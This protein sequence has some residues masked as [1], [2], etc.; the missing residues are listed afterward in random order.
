MI[1]LNFILVLKNLVPYILKVNLNIVFYYF[2]N[3]CDIENKFFSCYLPNRDKKMDTINVLYRKAHYDVCYSQ[4]Y[5]NK[6]EP[7]L[8]NYCKLNEDFCIVEPNMVSQKEKILNEEYPFDTEK[9][10]VFNRV[11]FAKRKKG[12]PTEKAKEKEN[13]KEEE[14]N[15][16]N[17]N[18]SINLQ[19]ETESKNDYKN[20]ITKKH[21]EENCLICGKKIKEE[22]KDVLPCKC[23]ISFCSDYC[24]E[25]YYK[26]LIS[27]FNSMEFTVNLKCGKCG[28]NINRCSFIENQNIENDNV[29]KALKNKILE[30]FKKYCMICLCKIT[31]DKQ[32]KIVNCKSLKLHKLLD[33]NKFEHRICKECF[34]KSSGNC[35]ICNLYHSRLVK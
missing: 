11:L 2:G 32:Y 20:T 25:K 22:K 30:F 17:F 28:N 8:N 13:K 3:E 15:L 35:K 12:N 16:N 27:F 23:N 6:Y 24:K 29:R 14:F 5:Y 31:L 10:V 34:K 26:S 4:E 18:M 21:C 33:T 9:S 19:E 1:Y 7:L